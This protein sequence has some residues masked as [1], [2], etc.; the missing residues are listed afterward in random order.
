MTNAEKVA[1]FLRG[2][3]TLARFAGTTAAVS[4]SLRARVQ[5]LA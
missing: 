1:N 2:R 3:S 5:M 4:K